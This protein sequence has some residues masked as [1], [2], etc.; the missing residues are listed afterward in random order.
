LHIDGRVDDVSLEKTVVITRHV[1]FCDPTK[2][3]T[4]TRR[5]HLTFLSPDAD[6]AYIFGADGFG[7]R[8]IESVGR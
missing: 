1:I 8:R 2:Q 5:S 6:P 3:A 7:K 4:V